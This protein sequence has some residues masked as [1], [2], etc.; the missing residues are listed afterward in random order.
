MRALRMATVHAS[1]L[2]CRTQTAGPVA[3]FWV[4]LIFFQYCGHAV[5]NIVAGTCGAVGLKGTRSCG[6]VGGPGQVWGGG[7]RRFSTQ[8]ISLSELLRL[9]LSH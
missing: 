4:K 1:A 6:A 7:A 9:D 8:V 3:D 2:R 5:R